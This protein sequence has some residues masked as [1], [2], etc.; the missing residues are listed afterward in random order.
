[1]RSLSGNQKC[2]HEFTLATD[3]HA[4]EAFEPFAFGDF[5]VRV[6][7]VAKQS[8]LFEADFPLPDAECEM[9]DQCV[10]QLLAANLRHDGYASP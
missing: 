9:L 2:L 10:R 8:H 1:M 5:G 6:A 3:D 7:P 4:W